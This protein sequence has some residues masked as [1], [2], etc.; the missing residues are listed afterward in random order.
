MDRIETDAIADQNG[1]VH[2]RWLPAAPVAMVMRLAL[3]RTNSPRTTPP[4]AHRPAM[5]MPA[6]SLRARPAPSLP[7]TDGGAHGV[8]A[9]QVASVD[10]GNRPGARRYRGHEL[11]TIQDCS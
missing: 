9:R 1:M 10:L 6:D 3:G 8:P 7:V 11:Q 2:V 4:S 5:P